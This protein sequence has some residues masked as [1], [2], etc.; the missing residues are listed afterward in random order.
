MDK[1]TQEEFDDIEKRWIGREKPSMMEEIKT[2]GDA[3][4]EITANKILE[5]IDRESLISRHL[6]DCTH[7]RERSFVEDYSGKDIQGDWDL[8]YRLFDTRL[9]RLLANTRWQLDNFRYIDRILNPDTS[10]RR[11]EIDIETI[12]Q[13]PITRFY[14]GKLKRTGDRQVGLCPFHKEKTPSFV[15]YDNNT[16]YCFGC[17][18]GGD[19]IDFYKRAN[20]VSTS[21]AI[22]FLVNHVT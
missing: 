15:I 2:M 7:I 17:G 11:K 3:L 9:K 5:L 21:K 22:R 16:F 14:A 18:V 12:R 4:R 13:V 10:R 1:L 20:D 19:V 8:W 6:L